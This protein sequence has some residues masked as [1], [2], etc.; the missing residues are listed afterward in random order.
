MP[1]LNG[2][3]TFRRMAVNGKPDQALLA[4][5]LRNI[6][7]RRFTPTSDGQTVTFGWVPMTDPLADGLQTEDVF[8]GEY[9]CLGFRQ[10]EKVVRAAD[11]RD[12]LKVRSR[13][14]TLQ[15]GRR[16]SRQEKTA[17]KE[18][19]VNEL[20][21][22]APIRRRVAEIVWDTRNAEARIFGA[23]KNMLT[24]LGE[25]FERTFAVG[26]DEFETATLAA[27]LGFTAIRSKAGAPATDETQA[28]GK[29]AKAKARATAARAADTTQDDSGTEADDGPPF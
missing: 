9:V 14:V 24:A 21:A 6:N 16:L 1:A 12:E 20:R 19:V 5:A 13:E 28:T 22:K 11:V 26:M 29:S 10:D 27:R 15:T 18:T 7:A 17:L 4:R 2:T 3:A 8:V 25:L 23:S